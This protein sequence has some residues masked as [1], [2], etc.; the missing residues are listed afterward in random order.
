M[1]LQVLRWV[2]ASHSTVLMHQVRIGTATAVHVYIRKRTSEHGY[3]YQVISSP[4]FPKN[5]TPDLHPTAGGS[6]R[7]FPRENPPVESSAWKWGRHNIRKTGSG[8]AQ[9]VMCALRWNLWLRSA[10]ESSRIIYR[11]TYAE[12]DGNRTLMARLAAWVISAA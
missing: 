5:R 7:A 3:Q 2:M 11:V 9:L 12:S 4:T 6:P 10:G 8:G 1:H